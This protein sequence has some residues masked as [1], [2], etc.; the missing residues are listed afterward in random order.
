MS[1]SD[2]S[3]PLVILVGGS[4]GTGKT[5]LARQ[6]ARESDASLLLVDDLRLAMQQ[7][8]SAATHPDLHVFSDPGFLKQMPPE[9]VRDG[10][11]AICRALAPALEIVVAHHLH[12]ALPIVIEGDGIL[13][14]LAAQDSF[15]GRNAEGRLRAVFLTA[16]SPDALL[17]SARARGRGLEQLSIEEQRTH[18]RASHLFG[19]WLAD[20]ARRCGV[21]VIP[22]APFESLVGRVRAAIFSP[23]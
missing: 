22:S 7:A 20:E 8:T 3:S 23:R 17:E 14:T 15:A 13:P 11:I 4:S 18:A 6:L 10:L 21:P 19:Q 16:A 12:V 2:R 1:D 9:A 5:E